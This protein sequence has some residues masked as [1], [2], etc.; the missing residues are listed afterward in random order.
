ML[1]LTLWM[2][3]ASSFLTSNAPVPGTDRPLL[4]WSCLIV[5][6]GTKG[7]VLNWSL[8]IMLLW[9][10]IGKLLSLYCNNLLI[11]D[12]SKFFPWCFLETTAANGSM[13]CYLASCERIKGEPVCWVF[14]F[15]LFLLTEFENTKRRSGR[16]TRLAVNLS[17]S[18]DFASTF[19]SRV[20]ETKPPR[21]FGFVK[22]N[23]HVAA[24][25]SQATKTFNRDHKEYDWPMFASER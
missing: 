22:P 17:S 10:G 20:Y 11:K 18:V 9:K 1:M 25:F 13:I 19:E 3:T 23:I 12:L 4:R 2:S 6:S 5:L 14:F 21:D 7:S 16:K 8:P 15:F 24:A